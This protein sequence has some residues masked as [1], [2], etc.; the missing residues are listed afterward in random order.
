MSP[1]MNVPWLPLWAVF[2]ITLGVVLVSILVGYTIGAR[3]KRNGP[4][5]EGPI[6]SAVGAMLGLLAFILA[7]T[8]GI[9]S[10]RFDSR[11]QLLLDDVT[12]LMTAVRRTDLLPEPQRTQSHALLKRIVD[13]QVEALRDLRTLPQALSEQNAM[14]D[15]LWAIAVPLTRTQ[16]NSPMGALYLQSLNALEE[17]HTRRVGV[18]L[19]FRIP[20]NVW[21]GLLFVTVFSMSGVGFQ[22]GIAGRG[23]MIVKVGLALA[24]AAVVVLIAQLD[25]VHLGGIE[26][27]QQPLLDLQARLSQSAP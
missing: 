7:F 9:A 18:A 12:T 22:F 26:V 24:F 1:G 19:Q 3:A 15:S 20:S 6:G 21:I 23:S 2:A 17:I 27:N 14:E 25:R 13:R 16:L 11:K 8:F 5:P 4:P 10:S